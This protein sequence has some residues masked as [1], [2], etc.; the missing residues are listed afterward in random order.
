MV[1]NVAKSLTLNNYN[2]VGKKIDVDI[3]IIKENLDIEDII[4]KNFV[5][6][7]EIITL[8]NKC[9]KLNRIVLINC[10]I[11]N[12]IKLKRICI[13]ELINCS[14]NNSSIFADSMDHLTIDC[15]DKID[16]S[17]IKNLKIQILKIIDTKVLNLNII[18][19]I[20][21]LKY[22]YLIGIKLNENI[23]YEKLIKLKELNLSYSEILNKEAYLKQFK[24]KKIKV[25]FETKE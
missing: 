13:L 5:V 3:N 16:I 25:T 19:E 6:N 1:R 9:K 12:N 10:D 8:L 21:T 23:N 22:L 11:K 7:D 17:Y 2:I 18:D 20:I 4:I 15:C 14:I 24:N